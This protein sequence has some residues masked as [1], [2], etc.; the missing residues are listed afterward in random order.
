VTLV[1]WALAWLLAIAAVALWSAPWW[2]GGAWLAAA[3][4]AVFTLLGRRAGL[5]VV[6]GALLALGGGWRFAHWLDRPPPDLVRYVDSMVEVVAVVD[7]EPDPGLTTAAYSV[8]AE[9][10]QQDGEWRATNGRA[11]VALNQYADFRPGTR[12]HLKGTLETPP[13]FPDFD[14]RAYLARQ[15]VVATMFQPKVEVAPLPPFSVCTEYSDLSLAA[16]NP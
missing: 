12:L 10:I 2:M 8:R 9:R 1:V 16:W 14:Y 6:V 3:S 11:R 13:R 15:D 5:V 7:A 4:P